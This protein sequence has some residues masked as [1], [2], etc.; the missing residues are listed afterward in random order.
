MLSPVYM[1]NSSESGNP[2][3]STPSQRKSRKR[4]MSSHDFNDITVLHLEDEGETQMMKNEINTL[5]TMINDLKDIVINQLNLV[6]AELKSI[7]EDLLIKANPIETDQK[8]D[9]I[10]NKVNEIDEKISANMQNAAP[11]SV[12][13]DNLTAN[14]PIQERPRSNVVRNKELNERK[15]AFYNYM[16]N[17]DRMEIY[18]EMLKQ[19]PPRLPA[20]FIPKEIRNEPRVEFEARQK[21]ETAKLTCYLECL[22]NRGKLAKE[23]YL[24][25]DTKVLTDIENSNAGEAEKDRQRKVW[26]EKTTQEEEISRKL[27]FKKR[28]KIISLP[29]VQRQNGRIIE[30][31]TDGHVS[32]AVIA[33]QGL[34]NPQE[35]NNGWTYVTNRR[36]RNTNYNH[37]HVNN[38]RGRG[39]MEQ[40][41]RRRGYPQRGNNNY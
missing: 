39:G 13:S 36:Q 2:S 23:K 4:T 7:K 22:E 5:K 26:T 33:S 34:N 21:L 38:S 8:I 31:N 40:S 12:T 16:H 37:T 9:D 25:V 35:D 1:M 17:S 15:I 3:V 10:R 41:F 32:Y 27:W 19:D 14:M 28:D 30:R 24:L 29:D 18:N 6:N 11:V 20:R